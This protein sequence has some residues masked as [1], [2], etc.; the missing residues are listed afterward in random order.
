MHVVG[1]QLQ[2]WTVRHEQRADVAVMREE[3]K[4]SRSERERGDGSGRVREARREVFARVRV[5]VMIASSLFFSSSYS[6]VV[7]WWWI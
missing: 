6:S 4:A 2:T 7:G 5:C 1:S 3:W